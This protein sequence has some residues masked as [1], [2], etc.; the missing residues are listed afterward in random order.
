MQMFQQQLAQ[1]VKLTAM[2]QAQRIM[3]G[4]TGPA[5]P[6]SVPTVNLPK[7]VDD[8][9]SEEEIK[10]YAKYLGMDVEADADLLYIAEWALT[11]P[12]PDGWTVHLDAGGSWR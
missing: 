9:P 10:E 11:A 3:T 5:M 6:T 7:E 4:G 12:C 1:T 8:P 2:L